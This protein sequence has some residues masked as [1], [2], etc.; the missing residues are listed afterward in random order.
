MP[1]KR[2]DFISMFAY[3]SDLFNVYNYEENMISSYEE[4]FSFEAPYWDIEIVDIKFEKFDKIV[5]IIE[6]IKSGDVSKLTEFSHIKNYFKG[7]LNKIQAEHS[8]RRNWRYSC[9]ELCCTIYDIEVE[10]IYTLKH[11]LELMKIAPFELF[12][13]M[14]SVERI[15][16]RNVCNEK[17]QPYDIERY[18]S[19]FIGF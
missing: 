12:E 1:S 7:V 8:D 14:K 9:P 15:S 13:I 4:L 11:L 19:E 18:I 6:K 2:E 17:R 16:L 3:L 5:D 10:M